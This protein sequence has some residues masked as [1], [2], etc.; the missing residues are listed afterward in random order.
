MTACSKNSSL[1]SM[2]PLP[3]PISRSNMYRGAAS[4]PRYRLQLLV[5]I[6]DYILAS[7]HVISCNTVICF[8]QQLATVG[9]FIQ[10]RNQVPFRKTHLAFIIWSFS[11]LSSSGQLVPTVC[12][13]SCSLLTKV[14]SDRVTR[15]C[16]PS[17]SNS[18]CWISWKAFLLTKMV[19]GGYLSYHSLSVS[20][21]QPGHSLLTS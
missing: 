20:L 7:E 1:L 18:T 4:N 17:A 8:S 13:V 11:S 21:K 12:S 19:K 16:T 6:M 10:N 5:N 14:E 15:C 9:T 3:I 2:N